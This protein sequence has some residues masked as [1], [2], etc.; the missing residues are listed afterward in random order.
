MLGFIGVVYVRVYR[1]Y[2]GHGFYVILTS[3]Y[4]WDV[5]RVGD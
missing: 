2:S 3:G 5:L 4:G 1:G